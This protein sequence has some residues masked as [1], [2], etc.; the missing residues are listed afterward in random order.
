M[1]FQGTRTSIAKKPYFCDFSGGSRPP[2]SSSGPAHGVNIKCLFLPC[3]RSCIIIAHRAHFS[4]GS[5]II[6]WL[7]ASLLVRYMYHK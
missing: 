2:V 3:K 6:L 1:I 5:L 7:T 4:S